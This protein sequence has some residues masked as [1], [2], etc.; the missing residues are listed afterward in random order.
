VGNGSLYKI[1][2]SKKNNEEYVHRVPIGVVDSV[3]SVLQQLSESTQPVSSDK[4][5]ESQ[6][7]KEAGDPPS[8]QVYIV[9]AY[10]KDRGVISSYGREGFHLPTDIHARL[11]GQLTEEEAD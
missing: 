5:L 10:L 7:L 8:Y 9:L 1:G 11:N 3:G 2:W 6:F 4:I